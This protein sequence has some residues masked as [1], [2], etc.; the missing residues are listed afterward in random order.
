MNAHLESSQMPA[1][2]AVLSPYIY[3]TLRI[4]GGGRNE[5]LPSLKLP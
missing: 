4:D 5:Y 3:E 2:Y 1:Y